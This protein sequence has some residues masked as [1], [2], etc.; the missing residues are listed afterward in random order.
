[1]TR[2]LIMLTLTSFRSFAV[3]A[4]LLAAPMGLLHA[5]LLS[6][7]AI[8]VSIAQGQSVTVQR[9]ITLSESGPAA[10]R[11]DV[12]F[13]ADNTGSMGGA[14]KAVKDNARAI[15]DAIAGGDQR[16]EGVDVAFG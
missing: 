8:N 6:P 13:L 5:A 4:M 9:S 1:M 15:L 14:V 11:V 3:F 10:N 2:T 7:D 16:F 12:V